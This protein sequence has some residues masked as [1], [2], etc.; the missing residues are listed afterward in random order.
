[1]QDDLPAALAR[2]RAG[3]YDLITD[4]PAD[5]YQW[6]QDNLPGQAKVA[7]FLGVYYYVINQEKEP[8]NNFDV[9]KALSMA[10]NR[11]VIGPDVLGTGELPA[12][13]WVPEGTANFWPTC[14]PITTSISR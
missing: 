14:G 8:F 13:G 4:F 11:D 6:I 10:I 9:R 3:E 1:M 12:Y 5:Q 7:P 2:Y